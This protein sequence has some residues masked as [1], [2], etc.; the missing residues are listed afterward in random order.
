V[1]EHVGTLEI[2][3]QRHVHGNVHRPVVFPG[4]IAQLVKTL[5]IGEFDEGR[6]VHGAGY[7]VNVRLCEA[8]PCLEERTDCRAFAGTDEA[9]RHGRQARH[10]H[11]LYGGDEVVVPILVDREIRVTGNLEKK[12]FLDAE[13]GK[14]ALAEGAHHVVEE[15]EV[16]LA[17]DGRQPD[18]A[19]NARRYLDDRERRMHG[20]LARIRMRFVE[21]AGGLEK[22]GK[23]AGRNGDVVLQQ[24]RGVEAEVPDARK[25]AVALGAER[26]K[27][28]KDV[29]H[30]KGVE[31]ADLL[32]VVLRR[33]DIME[34]FPG[35]AGED[36]VEE[37]V[38]LHL[39]EF[40]HP[41]GY[42][43][44]LFAD[45]KPGCVVPFG[46][47]AALGLE[48]RHPHHEELVEIGGHDREEPQPLEQRHAFLAGFAQY[49]GIEFNPGEFAVQVRKC[50]FF[51]VGASNHHQVVA[52]DIFEQVGLFFES[53]TLERNVVGA[54]GTQEKRIPG[55]LD[56][57]I[58]YV[59]GMSAV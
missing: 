59:L 29:R 18:D 42:A 8:H 11:F 3:P 34:P 7:P 30:E 48:A 43:F 22:I 19:G 23:R 32:G 24:K 39:Y 49:A 2:I 50:A 26:G 40:V 27:Q 56:V 47:A 36:I 4:R 33:G 20:C 44:E 21:N 35:E 31:K 1:Q 16:P 6:K 10:Q 28:G 38:V 9:H 57:E 45:G 37:A 54:P 17:V 41:Y 55:K 52:E 58:L 46:S 13:T 25:E 14:E 51:H 5:G 12:V 53:E 15:G